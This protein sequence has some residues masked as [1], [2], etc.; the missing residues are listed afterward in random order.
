MYTYSYE[1]KLMIFRKDERSNFPQIEVSWIELDPVE[2]DF[3][4]VF[5]HKTA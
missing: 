4:Y 3:S 5:C 2:I 1:S